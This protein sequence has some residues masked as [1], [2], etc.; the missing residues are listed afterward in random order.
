MTSLQLHN[1][2]T[3]STFPVNDRNACSPCTVLITLCSLFI[4]AQPIKPPAPTHQET[5]RLLLNDTLCTSSLHSA[6][7]LRRRPTSVTPSP[8]LNL[9]T[10]LCCCINCPT[11]TTEIPRP[12]LILPDTLL[13]SVY[14][15][16]LAGFSFGKYFPIKNNKLLVDSTIEQ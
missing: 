11:S 14:V 2:A 7:K 6:D 12:G 16:L 1:Q 9:S 8:P 10:D 3:K 4:L 15:L 5:Y 13:L